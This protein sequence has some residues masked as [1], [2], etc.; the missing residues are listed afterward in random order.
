MGLKNHI[1]FHS[2]FSQHQ[3]SGSGLRLRLYAELCGTTPGG[4][5][6]VVVCVA[7]PQCRWYPGVVWWQSPDPTW[8]R[9]VHLPSWWQ[10]CYIVHSLLGSTDWLTEVWTHQC[11]WFCMAPEAWIV[12]LFVFSCEEFRDRWEAIQRWDQ[13]W[14]HKYIALSLGVLWNLPLVGT[15]V[16]SIWWPFLSIVSKMENFKREL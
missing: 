14:R 9:S 3:S 11:P 4:A 12:E 15:Y 8:P 1:N 13:L 6:P 5:I 10:S 2:G 7:A 16:C